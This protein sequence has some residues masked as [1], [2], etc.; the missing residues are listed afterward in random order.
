MNKENIHD[1]RARCTELPFSAGPLVTQWESEEEKLREEE[2][3]R[4]RE[5]RLRQLLRN[6]PECLATF[7]T[8][9]WFGYVAA[10]LEPYHRQRVCVVL[11]ERYGKERAET[12][13]VNWN[14]WVLQLCIEISRHPSVILSGVEDAERMI[15]TLLALP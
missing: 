7:A 5:E 2:E 12:I 11:K 14:L 15:Q 1:L 10:L 13:F 8:E 9:P 6:V 3:E 4:R